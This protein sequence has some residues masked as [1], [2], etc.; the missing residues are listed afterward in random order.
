MMFNFDREKLDK[1]WDEF[2]DLIGSPIDGDAQF[3]S[4]DFPDIISWIE[5]GVAEGQKHGK[6]RMPGL[7]PSFIS[8]SSCVAAY[9]HHYM[10]AAK[11]NFSN[12]VLRIF[13]N[14]HALHSRYQRYLQENLYGTWKCESCKVL[15][16]ANSKYV[17]WMNSRNSASTLADLKDTTVAYQ[18]DV[19]IARPEKCPECG[20]SMIY[21]EWRVINE[22]NGIVGEIDGIVKNSRGDFVGLEFKSVNSRTFKKFQ[23]REG[24]ILL[25]Y[26]KQFAIYL[27]ELDIA[28]GL[29]VFE[30]KDTQ[31]VELLPVYLEE[32]LELVEPVYELV[33]KV[34]LF[35]LKGKIPKVSY[36]E[37]CSSCD[38]Y[39]GVCDPGR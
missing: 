33:N 5:H 13:D 4:A 7:H 37:D 25:K 14:G 17:S 23:Q 9:Y 36:N 38:F 28:Y 22:E 39:R 34:N 18:S 20:G 2:A 30:N 21:H 16:G 35:L 15:I 11:P 24:D 1:D 29:F 32:E 19:P 6:F 3:L 10:N 26:R 8:G 31:H 12:G 27:K